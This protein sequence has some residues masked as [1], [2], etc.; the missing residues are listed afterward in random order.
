MT[1]LMTTICRYAP[2]VLVVATL[3][4][5]VFAPGTVHDM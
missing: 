4:A 1:H 2:A 3:V 5:T